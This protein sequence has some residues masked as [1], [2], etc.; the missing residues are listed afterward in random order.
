MWNRFVSQ[1]M[2]GQS[3]QLAI[4]MGTMRG[5]VRVASAVGFLA[6]LADCVDDGVP[7]QDG[8]AGQSSSAGQAP[9]A[10]SGSNP[11]PT[12]GSSTVGTGGT[13][14]GN[15]GASG[16]SHAG[17]STAGASANGGTASGGVTGGG[18]GSGGSGGG[19]V[20]TPTNKVFSQCRLHFGTL[21]SKAKEKGGCGRLERIAAGPPETKCCQEG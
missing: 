11:T 9:L 4:T 6:L 5:L 3:C 14:A 1:K 12:A 8:A 18:G 13:A 20:V 17:S 2:C 15:V 19:G 7:A 10:G 16:S 21:D